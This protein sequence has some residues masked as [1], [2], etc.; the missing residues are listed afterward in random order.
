MSAPTETETLRT[1]A[2][3]AFAALVVGAIAMG[4]SP[5]F[6]RLADVG[7]FTSAFWRVFLALPILYLWALRDEGG[8]FSRI[9]DSWLRPAIVAGV[10]FA[11]DLFFWHLSILTTTV[12]NATFFATMAPVFVLLV[13]WLFF[14][15]RIE[16]RSVMGLG[17]CLFGGAML[18]GASLKIAPERL[19]GDGYGLITAMF[20]AGYIIALGIARARGV[21]AGK[22]SFQLTAVCAAILFIIAILFER[23]FFPASLEGWAAVIALAIITQV[24]GQGL[25]AYALGHLPASYSSLVMFLEG[26]AAAFLGWLV[27]S[28][29]L[30]LL[31]C[32]GAAMIFYGVFHARPR[33][34]TA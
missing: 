6:V 12:A 4:I 23:Q 15:E 27:L 10:F 34:T 28:E 31:Q 16:R 2:P 9:M 19:V 32:A 33:R 14:G 30:T 20:F 7:P 1:G 21:S 25:L 26:I 24:G 13:V 11:G 18:I 29:A 8:R 17:F 22:A 3:L 5:I